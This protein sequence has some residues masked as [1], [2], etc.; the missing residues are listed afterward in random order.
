LFGRWFG[1]K[2]ENSSP[3]PQLGV[4][5]PRILRHSGGWAMMRKR[6]QAEQG[7]RVLDDGVTSPA[8]INLLTDMGHS[9]FLS[10][11]VHDA[12][13]G[14]WQTGEDETGNPIWDVNG[15]LERSLNFSGRSFDIVLLWAALDYLPEA[16]VEPVVARLYEATNAGGQLLALFHTRSTGENTVHCRFNLTL[17]DELELQPEEPFRIHHCFTNRSIERIFS[18]WAGYKQ[19]LAKDNVSEVVITR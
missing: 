7:L 19:F 8:N 14:N 10:D 4:S 15:F 12:K 11:L 13:S 2:K 3:V 9:V 17:N 18:N 5:G 1:N 16:F 6:L